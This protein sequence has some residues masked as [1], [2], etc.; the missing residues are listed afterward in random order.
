[1]ASKNPSPRVAVNTAISDTQTPGM[2]KYFRYEGGSSVASLESSNDGKRIQ[3]A[4]PHMHTRPPKSPKGKIKP[5]SWK[6]KP[7]IGGPKVYPKPLKV[8]QAPNIV[9]IA[10]GNSLAMIVKDAKRTK[11]CLRW[12]K[13]W[14]HQHDCRRIPLFVYCSKVP[15]EQKYLI[16]R[17]HRDK[18]LPPI[19]F[20][21]VWDN[22]RKLS[23]H[24]MSKALVLKTFCHTAPKRK[25]P[26]KG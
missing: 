17:K 5:P 7:P 25:K 8:S 14:H 15:H 24:K 3:A 9:D 26:K 1:M 10:C 21:R 16:L 20:R 13:N 19:P 22:W 4:M 11:S 2:E 18:N 12:A 23:F 6:R